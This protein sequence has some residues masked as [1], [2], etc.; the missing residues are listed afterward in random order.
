MR[1]VGLSQSA[2]GPLYLEPSGDKTKHP[3]KDQ[4]PPLPPPHRTPTLGE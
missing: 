2:R 1:P 3:P 4:L